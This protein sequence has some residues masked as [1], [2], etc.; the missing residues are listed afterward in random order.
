MDSLAKK[1]SKMAKALSKEL[2][3]VSPYVAGSQ[4]G[5]TMIGIGVGSVTEPFVTESLVELFGHSVPRAISFTISFLVVTFILVVVGELLPKYLVLNS[6]ER[7][8]LVTFRPLKF[9]ITILRPLIWLVQGAARLLLRLCGV[10]KGPDSGSVAKEELMMLVQTGGAEGTLDK[11]HAEMVTRALK[12][13]VLD[14]RDIMVH[15]L[16][17]KWLDLSLTK[18]ELLE[19]IAAIPFTRL[20]VCRGDI[21]DMV[22]VAYLHDIVKNLHRSD[23]KLESLM[24]PLVA[25]PE[26]LTMEKIVATMRDQKTQILVV[27]DEYG[28]TSGLITLEDVVEEI[29]GELE[30][31]LESERPH[32]EVFANGRVSARS[33]V[34]LD[35]IIDF[36]HLPIESGENTDTLAQII[37]D[38]LERV[39]RPGDSVETD[40]GKMRVENMA[41]RRVT[42]VSIQLKPELT[43]PANKE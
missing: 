6:P 7:V 37:V 9:I 42:R 36:L 13:D 12:L 43:D 32:I 39:P 1:G 4:I 26:N 25:I 22:G 11:M 41:R 5:V 30:D 8:A 33:D 14:A 18:D 21:D 35:E 40:L 27:M 34:R 38:T 29:F 17:V 24:R 15:R 20:P 31:R 16:D 19:K 28:G 23:F 3:D 2:E 10:K